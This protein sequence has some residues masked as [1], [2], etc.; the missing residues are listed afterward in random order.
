MPDTSPE[1]PRR[2]RPGDQPQPLITER[3]DIM[4]RVAADVLNR[5][6]TG[7]QRYRTTLQA[8]NGR[9]ALTDSYEELLDAAAYTRQLL[10]E[11]DALADRARV[12]V[13][14]DENLTRSVEQCGSCKVCPHQTD[15]VMAVITS[16]L[17]SL[18]AGVSEANEVGSAVLADL[19]AHATFRDAKYQAVAN[20]ITEALARGA[21]V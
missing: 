1:Q 5:R 21:R 10:D 9:D 6:D 8:F 4:A 2:E 20:R 12:A 16:L 17:T 14:V 13:I 18:T 7:I 11:R 15:A 19:L 3:P